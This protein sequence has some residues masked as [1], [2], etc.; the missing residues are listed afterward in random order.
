MATENSTAVRTNCAITLRGRGHFGRR[1]LY[2]LT[3]RNAG[4]GVWRITEFFDR[5]TGAHWER[6]IISYAYNAGVLTKEEMAAWDKVRTKRAPYPAQLGMEQLYKRLLSQ[7]V[8]VILTDKHNERLQAPEVDGFVS[9]V[10]EMGLRSTVHF[11]TQTVLNH[12]AIDTV[13]PF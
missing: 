9:V 13:A 5:T 12:L 8:R 2:D 3:V 6:E 7:H 4:G 11:R 1:P 10:F